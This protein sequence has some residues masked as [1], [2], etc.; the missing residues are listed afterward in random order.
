MKVEYNPSFFKIHNFKKDF[1]G[2]SPSV[3]VGR[4]GYPYV[5][6]GLLA[7]PKILEDPTVYDNPR[8]WSS[9]NFSQQNIID[10]RSNLVNSRFKSDIKFSNRY[11]EIAREVSMSLKG[12]DLEVNLKKKPFIK[13]N[14]YQFNAPTGSKAELLKARVTSNVKIDSR[15]DKVVDDID[16][17]A[18]EAVLYLHKKGFQENFLTKLISLGNLGLK[19]NRKL[20]PSRWS[21]TAI[22]DIIGKNIIYEIK[23]FETLDKPRLYYEDYFGNYY[24]ILMFPDVWGYELYEKKYDDCWTD[25]EFYDGRKTYAE[26]IA[27]GYYANRVVILEKL[28]ELKKQATIF[29]LRIVTDEYKS[30]LG[31]WVCREAT[32]KAMEKK[33]IE[34]ESEGLMLNFLK[35]T[36][37]S[38]LNTDITNILKQSKVLNFI[39]SQVRL[40]KFL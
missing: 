32:R 21:I 15:V 37:K 19:K 7:P 34:F 6:V 18:E 8:L 5:N 33:P 27:G 39:K 26:D 14:L 38:K 17:K 28:K 25:F 35:T 16:L 22:D 11:I 29:S 9:E 10:L 4:F 2:S 13:T 1:F 24:F 12:A 23:S 3:F 36:V 20:V 40:T 30:P 31:V